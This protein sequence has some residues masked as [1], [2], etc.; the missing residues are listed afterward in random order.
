MPTALN[1]ELHIAAEH[2]LAKVSTYVK[3]YVLD[4]EDLRA[5]QFVVAKKDN[6]VIGFGRLRRHSDALELCTLGVVEQHRRKGVGRAIVNE[7][8]KKAGDKLYVV[9]IIPAFFKKLGFTETAEFPSSIA[10]KHHRC[11]TEYPVPEKYCVMS[12][13]I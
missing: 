11:T 7:L 10:R 1:I 9:C 5:E 13:K 3:K 2:D 6:E 12:R 4:S 8:V